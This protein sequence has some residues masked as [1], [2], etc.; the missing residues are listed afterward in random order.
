MYKC[1]VTSSAVELDAWTLKCYICSPLLLVSLAIRF[2]T[3]IDLGAFGFLLL[4][5]IAYPCPCFEYYKTWAHKL[6]FSKTILRLPLTVILLQHPQFLTY[7]NLYIFICFFFFSFHRCTKY[8]DTKT[9]LD[10][11]VLQ[12][13]NMEICWVSEAFVNTVSQRKHKQR[14][15]LQENTML[16]C[17]EWEHKWM[18]TV[19]WDSV[20]FSW[21]TAWDK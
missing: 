10:D 21:N 9:I 13:Q 3:C 1:C 2:R 7:I 14:T 4:L 18:D 11:N 12:L 16:G 5:H 20:W 15:N 6:H 8:K 19:A 17:H